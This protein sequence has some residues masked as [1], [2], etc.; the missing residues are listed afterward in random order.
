MLYNEEIIIIINKERALKLNYKKKLF[1]CPE[2]FGGCSVA[3]WGLSRELWGLSI[4][5]LSLDHK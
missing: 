5:R 4:N 2:Q 3:I 1:F